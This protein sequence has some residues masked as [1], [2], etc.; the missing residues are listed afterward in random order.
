MPGLVCCDL[1]LALALLVVL[2]CVREGGK[3]FDTFQLET[4]SFLSCFV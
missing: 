3:T 4:G 1:A 2:E